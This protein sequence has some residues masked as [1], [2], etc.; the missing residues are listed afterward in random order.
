MKEERLFSDIQALKQAT[1][2]KK[3]LTL[4]DTNQNSKP[5]ETENSSLIKL[6]ESTPKNDFLSRFKLLKKI[7]EANSKPLD[8]ELVRRVPNP[9]LKK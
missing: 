2:A 1:V 7:T 6:E 4:R 9:Y 3:V 8:V 5:N